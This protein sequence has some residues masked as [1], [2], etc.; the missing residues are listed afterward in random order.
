MAYIVLA[1][2]YRPQ[3]FDDV[4]GQ[5]SAG[6]TLKNAIMSGRVAHAYLFAGPRGVGKTSMARILAKALNCE[7]GPTPEPDNS[8]D[9]CKSITR[10]DDVDVIEI[11]AASNRG[12]DDARVLRENVKYMPTRGRY[13]IYIID[14]VHM[15]TNE[16]FNALLKTLEEPPPHVRFILATTA[17]SKLPDTIRSRCQ[18]L[19]F[20]RITMPKIVEAL[21]RIG[22]AEGVTIEPA[23]LQ[24]IARNAR[25]GLRDS[26]SL[27]DQLIS[28]SGKKITEADVY[29]TIG[30]LSRD[31]LF[32]LV[33]LINAGNAPETLDVLNQATLKGIEHDT[34]LD[35]LIEHYR[36]LLLL[37]LCGTGSPL[38]DDNEEDI[39]RL[40][41]QQ[42]QMSADTLLYAVQVLCDAKTKIKG[43]VESRIPVEMALIRLARLE[44]L[45]SLD[46]LARRLEALEKGAGAGRGPSAPPAAPAAGRP[47]P[48]QYTPR[49][50]QPE[51]AKERPARYAPDGQAAAPPSVAEDP[52][53]DGSPWG[54]IV[55]EVGKGSRLT[56]G[57]LIGIAEQTDKL[58]VVNH[59]KVFSFRGDLVEAAVRKVLNTTARVVCKEATSAAGDAPGQAA[60][61]GPPA[62]SRNDGAAAAGG[63]SPSDDQFARYNEDPAVKNVLKSFQG[64]IV[65]VKGAKK[66]P[67]D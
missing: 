49:A 40:E 29:E 23:A 17:P 52:P 53:P 37:K 12:I 39:A 36:E 22:D 54:R 2:R 51:P 44:K 8:C 18:R 16:A 30:A 65:G 59:W 31:G 34:F 24:A 55:A 41:A 47:A 14:E 26:E 5:E 15:L 60:S 57:T 45:V 9:I 43:T 6:Q 32:K 64:R 63:G 13:K 27:L 58:V 25:G 11:D 48:Q 4:I 66:W 19:D 46:E 28:F 56:A 21:K 35:E 61:A 38:I 67:K 20:K 50:R 7:K 1:R 62:A 10:G 3:S 42:Q 33:E